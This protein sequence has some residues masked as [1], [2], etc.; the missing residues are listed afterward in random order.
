MQS[1]TTGSV[2][3]PILFGFSAI[4]GLIVCVGLACSNVFSI[5]FSF[6]LGVMPTRQNEVSALMIM[7][8]SGGALL[9][10]VMGLVADQFGQ[11]VAFGLLGENTMGLLQSFTPKAD[12]PSIVVYNTLNWTYSGL[13]KAYIDHQI[14]PRNKAFEIVDAQGTIKQ[15]Y[16]KELGRNLLSDQPEWEMGEF[17]YEIIDSRRPMELYKAPQFLRR[18]PEKMRFECYEQGKIHLD[19]PGGTIEAG[20]DQIKGSSNDWYTVQNFATARNSE[21][22]IVMG[23]QEIPLMQFGAINTGRYEAGAVPQSTHMYSWPMNNYWVT[24]FNADQMG[25]IQWSYFIH[26]AADNSIAYATRFAWENRIPF[27]TRVLPAGQSMD[28]VTE[29][30]GSLFRIVPDNLLLVNMR[31]VEGEKAVMLQLREIGGKA[32]RFAVEPGKVSP[33]HAQACDVVGT[34]IGDSSAIDFLPWENKLIKL[35]W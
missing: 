27:L 32:V 1:K 29:T 34:P 26:S 25:V 19:V 30:S 14:L 4:A 35:C 17:I 18:R 5:L 3:F 21:S 24:N 7:G 28:R 20:V 11:V 12:C 23:S 22:Q 10:P 13:A 6:A 9:T 2:L 8:V 31:P 33:K 16:D 15:L